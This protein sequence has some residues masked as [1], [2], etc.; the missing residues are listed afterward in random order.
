L[1]TDFTVY[2]PILFGN[3]NKPETING[4]REVLFNG[5]WGRALGASDLDS[6]TPIVKWLREV[7]ADV[8]REHK[9][10]PIGVIGNCL[11][12]SLPLLLLDNPMVNA[13]VVAQPTLPIRIFYH[14]QDDRWS[15]GISKMEL[16]KAKQIV[17]DRN[18][19]VYGVRFE[20]DCVSK[21]EKR[22]TLWDEFGDRY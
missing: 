14:S 5:E 20:N 17:N 16:N 15:L 18:M 13:V 10:S 1:S 8:Q 3:P 2:I 7:T 22:Y 6:N 4:L 19:K 9:G 12:G 11:T 21:P